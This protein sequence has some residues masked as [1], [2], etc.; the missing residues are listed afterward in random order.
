MAF[1]GFGFSAAGVGSVIG[2]RATARYGGG[3]GA[4]SWVWALLVTQ[5]ALL[6]ALWSVGQGVWGA[7]AFMASMLVYGAA[8]AYYNVHSLTV[9]QLVSPDG[10]LGRVNAVY[11]TFA[12]GT[13]PI[14][15]GLAA[16][17]LLFTSAPM[18]ATLVA[19]LSVVA[20][21]V[22]ARGTYTIERRDPS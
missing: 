10:V 22:L 6:A 3:D 4:R 5:L 12:F 1:L 14:G 13:I 20:T 15:A 18:A 2:A 11:R 7:V 8:M 17:L 19:G 16:L 9:R 21:W